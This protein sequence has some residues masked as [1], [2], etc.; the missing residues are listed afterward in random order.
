M[1]IILVVMS[2]V[3]NVIA[4]GLV[5]TGGD[6]IAALCVALGGAVTLLVG[7]FLDDILTV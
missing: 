6:I 1:E 3:L 4:L 2:V 5:Y 7:V